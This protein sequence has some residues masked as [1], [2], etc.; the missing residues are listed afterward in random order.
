MIDALQVIDSL[1][2]H[3]SERELYLNAFRTPLTTLRFQRERIWE[4]AST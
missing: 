3:D 1:A 2:S 4:Y